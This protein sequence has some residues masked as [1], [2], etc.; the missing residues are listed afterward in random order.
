MSYHIN[1]ITYCKFV[2]LSLFRK[3][4][5]S[6]SS[7]FMTGWLSKGKKDK[8]VNKNETTPTKLNESLRSLDKSPKKSASSNFMAGWL[9]KAKNSSSSEGPPTKKQK[10]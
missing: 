6:A 4:K 8:D 3:P 2:V 5:T 1:V 10:L 7:N 9:S